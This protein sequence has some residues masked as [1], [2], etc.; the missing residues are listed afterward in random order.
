M[1]SPPPAMSLLVFASIVLE[2]QLEITVNCAYPDSLAIQL[3]ES[4]V[5]LVPVLLLGGALVAHASWMFPTDCQHVMH[6]RRAT[7]GGTV[8]FARMG[9]LGIQL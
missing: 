7:P 9:I 1:A 4:P 8:M 6:V 5:S 3:G 2:T